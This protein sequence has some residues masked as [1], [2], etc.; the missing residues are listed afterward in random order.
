MTR[1]YLRYGSRCLGVLLVLVH[2]TAGGVTAAGSR[3]GSDG[4]VMAPRDA[5]WATQVI[6][7]AWHTCA[8]TTMGGVKCWGRNHH[9]QLGDGSLR[10]R[11]LPVDVV[12]LAAGVTQLSAGGWHTCVVTAQG[13][14][15]CWGANDHGQ[16]GDGTMIDRLLPTPVVGLATGVRAI[17]AGGAHTCA[18]LDTGAV[19]CWG[20]NTYGQLGDGTTSARLLPSPVVGFEAGVLAISAGGSHTCAVTIIGGVQCWGDNRYGAVG[21]G[22]FSERLTP[23]PVVGLAAGVTAVSAGGAG[24]LHTCA[25]TTTGDALCWGWNASGQLGVGNLWTAATPRLVSGLHTGLAAVSTGY[26]HTCAT[27]TAG[28]AQCWGENVFGQLGDNTRTIR[29]TPVPVVD[30][31]VGVR[32][33]SAGGYHSCALLGTGAVYCWGDNEYG[34]LG[35]GTTTTR[36]TPVAVVRDVPYDCGAAT[37][38]PVSECTA[39]VTLFKASN[40]PLWRHQEGWLQ[41]ATPCGWY[42]V[43]CAAGHISRLALPA[44]QLGGALPAALAGVIALPALQELDLPGNDLDGPLPDTLAALSALQV[45][46]LAE[47][48]LSGPLPTSLGQLTQLTTLDLHG[49]AL[50][51]PLLA[52]LGGLAALTTLDLHNNALTGAIP[53]LW[54]RLTALR[55]LDL[56]ANHLDGYL[57]Q[58]LGALT[59][60][61]RLD[62]SHNALR[63]YTLAA[64]AQLTALRYLDLSANQFGGPLP[65]WPELTALQHLDLSQ[66]AFVGRLPETGAAL[67]NLTDV[68]LYNNHLSGGIPPGWGQLGAQLV[69]TP[70]GTTP[71]PGVYLDLSGNHLYGPIPPELGQNPAIRGL[72]LAG[73]QLSGPVPAAITARTYFILDLSYNALTVNT[74][75]WAPWVATQTLPPLALQATGSATAV[76]LTWTPVPYYSPDSDT[77]DFAYEISVATAPEGPFTVQGRT[78]ANQFDAASYTVTDLAPGTY[79]F[80]VRTFTAAHNYDA[81][82]YSWPVF[83]HEYFQPNNLWSDYTPL[84]SVTVGGTVT[85]TPTV[86]PTS[87]PGPAAR[88]FL[89]LVLV[90]GR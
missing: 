68:A 87:T 63:A 17:S 19:R 69:F 13:A 49:N 26:R 88:I 37:E 75:R 33:S 82:A 53:S 32:G 62:L 24:G 3:A 25:V 23:V 11:L 57:P 46:N 81:S 50:S 67:P 51:G 55:S 70:T 47:N 27:T 5:G 86:T 45:L 9:G 22:T 85:P 6:A 60:L 35:D 64:V 7:G 28:A 84:V 31:A 39:L 16:L 48:R 36:L 76:T 41:T 12:G 83:N 1:R 80:R 42:G 30:L 21:D 34:Q 4:V 72:Q 65:W 61:E 74:A 56:R 40:G 77:V 79:Y 43:T 54:R 58:E 10:S 73:N 59:A 71:P 2:L 38:L 18:L 14:V 8:L 20:D 89:P 78:P 15:K 66:N 90:G 44:N 29:L 52:D